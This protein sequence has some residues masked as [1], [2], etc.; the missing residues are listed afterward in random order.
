[1][2]RCVF[3]QRFR[4]RTWSSQARAELTVTGEMTPETVVA[5]RALVTHARAAGYRV[6]FDLSQVERISPGL[7]DLSFVR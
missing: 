2:V 6:S 4:L 3:L 7:L 1:M 5:A